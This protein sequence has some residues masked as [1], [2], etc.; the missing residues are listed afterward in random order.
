MARNAPVRDGST[1]PMPVVGDPIQP[2]M[3]VEV[4]HDT[5]WDS[6]A[7][8][9]EAAVAVAI[10]AFCVWCLFALSKPPTG[11]W[12]HGHYEGTTWVDG[13]WEGGRPP[14]D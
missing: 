2:P 6:H 10:V 3:P 13:H 11:R 12:V 4:T 1:L 5:W 7:S 9:I 8:A 14:M